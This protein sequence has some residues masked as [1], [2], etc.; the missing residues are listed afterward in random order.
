MPRRFHHAAISTPDLD[1]SIAFYRDRLGFEVVAE[2]AW[3]RGTAAADEVM[4]LRDSSGRAAMLRLGDVRLEL[5][6]FATPSAHPSDP[7]RPVSD[8]GITHLCFEVDDVQAEYERLL[9]LGVPFTCRP[10]KV[11]P[12]TFATYGRDPDGN[13]IELLEERPARA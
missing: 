9:A 8:H 3:P 5:F 6:E 13:V 1:R 10:R 4:G 12:A 2:F 11:G 7:A